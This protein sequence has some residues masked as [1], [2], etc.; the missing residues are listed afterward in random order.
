MRAITLTFICLFGISGLLPWPTCFAFDFSRE[1]L[2]AVAQEM[3]EGVV[4]KVDRE[5]GKITIR[6][7]DIPSLSMPPMSMVFQARDATLL[8]TVK[9]GDTIR[10]R[11]EEDGGKYYVRELE[12]IR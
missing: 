2:A 4:R 3:T 5:N 8:E 10:F 6:H 7:G 12:V 9:P 11:A 1:P